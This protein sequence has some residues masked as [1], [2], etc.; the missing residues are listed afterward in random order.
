[1]AVTGPKITDS[2]AGWS[3]VSAV[4]F[5]IMAPD[6]ADECFMNKLKILVALTGL[7]FAGTGMADADIVDRIQKVGEVCVEGD[8]GCGAAPVTV[9]SGGGNIEDQYNSGCAACHITGA[10]GAPKLG[11]LAAW[12]PRLA[13]GIDALYASAIQGMPPAMPP[14]GICGACSDDEVKAL[15]DYMVSSVE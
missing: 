14:K 4:R 5:C 1:M 10:A 9:A 7:L 3:L 2:A 12:E 15:V 6:F 11:D 8:E 13:K